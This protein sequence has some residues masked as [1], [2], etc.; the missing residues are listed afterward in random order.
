AHRAVQPLQVAVDH[1]HQVVEA[2]AAGDADRAEGFRLVGFAVAEE[3]PD[4]A[5]GLLHQTARLEVLRAAGRVDRRQ[6]AEAHAHG[7]GLPDVL[8]QP[9]VRIAADAA[10]V[11]LHAEVVELRFADAAFEDGARVDARLAVALD[12]QQITR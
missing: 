3:A 11:D 6:R 12:V 8:H 1:E 2:L 5:V 7:R 9:R 4:L 10:A